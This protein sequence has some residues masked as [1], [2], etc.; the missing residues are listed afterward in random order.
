[1]NKEIYFEDTAKI[2]LKQGFDKLAKAVSST[3][4]PNGK[5][6]IIQ[7]DDKRSIITK[8]GVTVAHHINLTDPV[9]NIGAQMLKEVSLL[10]NTQAGDGT[11]TATVLAKEILDRGFKEL[12]TK[13]GF[14]IKNELDLDLVEILHKLNKV[15]SKCKKTDILKVAKVSTN[16]DNKLSKLI[17]D[18]YKESRDSEIIL[19][20]SDT[21][22]TYTEF[23]EGYSCNTSY[24]DSSYVNYENNQVKFLN[25]VYFIFDG[26][27]TSPKKLLPL[28]D[29]VART[30]RPL[31]IIAEEVNN[32]ILQTSFR[33][34][35]KVPNV[36]IKTPGFGPARQQ[37]LNDIAV[38]TKGEVLNDSTL[39]NFSLSQLGQSEEVLIKEDSTIITGGKFNPE[40]LESYISNLEHLTKKNSNHNKQKIKERISKFRSGVGVIY[41][42]ATSE[43]EYK[44]KYDRIEDAVN[45]VK[46]ALEE[47]I[48]VGAGLALHTIGLE[49][50]SLLFNAIRKPYEIISNG[51]NEINVID[52]IDP[53]KVTKCA[54]QNAVSVT[55]TI[56]TTE[57]VI[58]NER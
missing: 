36:I 23:I 54:L 5:T 57:T 51:L 12:E 29:Q 14:D 48:V 42:G 34:I 55:S 9:E 26:K 21:N 15:S 19:E 27:L 30:K 25:P 10:T 20:A 3:L 24:I 31:V 41:I 28:F 6:V 8:D 40:D 16:G 22:D 2:K 45:A 53:V 4:G 49:K 17:A 38:Y 18:L 37:Y 52:I 50:D 58:V 32:D 39:P 7:I 47:G 44:E 43:L 56:L 33:N 46:A 11:T 1:M 35:G 13:S